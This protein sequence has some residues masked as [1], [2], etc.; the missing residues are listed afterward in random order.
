MRLH[1]RLAVRERTCRVWP[2]GRPLSSANW[3]S[4][5]SDSR[6]LAG[7]WVA[8][9][10]PRARPGIQLLCLRANNWV[11][12]GVGVGGRIRLVEWERGFVSSGLER[13]LIS[14]LNDAC[15]LEKLSLAL[16]KKGIASARDEAVGEIYRAHREQTDEHLLQ[17]EARLEAY[18]GALSLRS[19]S[20]S[21]GALDLAFDAG[22]SHTSTQLAISAYALENV[23]IAPW[24]SPCAKP[25]TSQADPRRA[26]NAR[27]SN[28]TGLYRRG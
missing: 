26:R 23:E 6:R 3:S 11:S 5:S 7:R 10:G 4:A 13:E 24:Q 21:I 17:I 12:R 19:G 15:A 27:P 9:A 8:L 1:G 25:P 28:R 14:Y 22:R 20:A 18:G 2:G 16:L